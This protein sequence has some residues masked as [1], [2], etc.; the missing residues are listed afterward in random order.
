MVWQ[1]LVVMV[2]VV[3][4]VVGLYWVGVNSGKLAS[5]CCRPPCT[6]RAT[7]FTGLA[8]PSKLSPVSPACIADQTARGKAATRG[9][10]MVRWPQSPPSAAGP[11]VLCGR[12]TWSHF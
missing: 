6:H 12:M 9:A 8:W 4:V 5:D 2:V 7:L 10:W 1:Q 3:V 11:W